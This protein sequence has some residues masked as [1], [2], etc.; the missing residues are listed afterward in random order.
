MA[1]TRAGPELALMV[2]C[3]TLV[4]V[5]SVSE[6]TRASALDDITDVRNNEFVYVY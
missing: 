2:S 4:S 5:K 6:L 1:K 3:T